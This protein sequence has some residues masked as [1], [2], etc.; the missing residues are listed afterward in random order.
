MKL[1]LH[2]FQQERVPG[3]APRHQHLPAADMPGDLHRHVFHEGGQY[4]FCRQAEGIDQQINFRFDPFAARIADD[5]PFS[6]SC[7]AWSGIP[8]SNKARNE[9]G[10]RKKRPPSS[11]DAPFGDG[12]QTK[13]LCHSFGL[14]L[15]LSC[16]SGHYILMKVFSLLS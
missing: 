5:P 14:S 11:P 8:S 3:T 4:R 10:S 16:P 6:A 12:R 13:K 2:P 7:L 1:C 15:S 9:D